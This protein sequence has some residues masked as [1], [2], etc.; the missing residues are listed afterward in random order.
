MTVMKYVHKMI[1]TAYSRTLH[2]INNSK[3]SWT[4]YRTILSNTITHI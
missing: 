4:K 2:M 3:W 1:R